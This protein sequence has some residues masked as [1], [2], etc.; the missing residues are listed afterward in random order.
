VIVRSPG[1]AQLI[2]REL[3]ETPEAR[4]ARRANDWFVNYRRIWA[5]S[6]RA[7]IGDEGERVRFFCSRLWPDL[8]SAVVEEVTRRKVAEVGGMTRPDTAEAIV[9]ERLATLMRDHGYRTS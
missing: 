2:E 6:E 8:S 9:G 3:A 7:G 1:E 5:A 4:A